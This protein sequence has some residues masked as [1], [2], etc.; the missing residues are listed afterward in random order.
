MRRILEFLSRN[1]FFFTFVFLELIAFWAIVN[2]NSFQET[3]Y[4]RWSLVVSARLDEF[5][6][7]FTNK[8]QLESTNRDLMET[9]A[10]LYESLRR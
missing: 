10:R 4:H 3:T 9:N 1:R 8:L 6:W 7:N 2:R 5:R